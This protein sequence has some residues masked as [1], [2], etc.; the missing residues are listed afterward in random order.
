MG[1]LGGVVVMWDTRVVEK[2]DEAVGHF[3]IEQIQISAK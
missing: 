1:A 3:S 2:I